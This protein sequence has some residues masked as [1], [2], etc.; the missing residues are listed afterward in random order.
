MTQNAFL[1]N[2]MQNVST[3]PNYLSSSK[4]FL[5][6]SKSQSDLFS[7][8]NLK[9]PCHFSYPNSFQPFGNSHLN[10][11]PHPKV[12]SPSVTQMLQAD[13]RSSYFFAEFAYYIL[14]LFMPRRKNG[15]SGSLHQFCH[16]IYRAY[17]PSLS[18]LLPSLAYLERVRA[19]NPTWLAE[20]PQ[21][22]LFAVSLV[23]ASKYIDDHPFTNSQFASFFNF[24][25]L[26][27]NRLE[28]EL[29]EIS[30]YSIS[31]NSSL[32][33]SW[34]HRLESFVIFK[35]SQTPLYFFPSSPIHPYGSV[36][37]TNSYI[38]HYNLCVVSQEYGKYSSNSRP[39]YA[40]STFNNNNPYVSGPL[41]TYPKNLGPSRYLPSH[42]SSVVA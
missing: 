2:Q 26:R 31:F 1:P 4:I 36:N 10:S 34:C 39:Q 22:Q 13:S 38:C 8:L 27:L 16:D 6:C 35:S 7:F 3:Y 24:D 17:S 9:D 14:R 42:Y 15:S 11:N 29:F 32:F 19:K 33:N 28:L 41:L 40:I 18:C 20:Q 21:D 23:L 12:W 25:R 5:S 37:T 30:N